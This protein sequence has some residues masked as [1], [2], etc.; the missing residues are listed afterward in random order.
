MENTSA[1]S[2]ILRRWWIVALCAVL[3]GALGGLPKPAAPE[4]D[5]STTY[6]ATHTMLVNDTQ[7]LQSSSNVVSPNQVSLLATTGEVPARV[8]E[9]IGSDLNSATLASQISVIFDPSTA[10]TFAIDVRRATSV[11]AHVVS[12]ISA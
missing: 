4:A 6:R 11:L 9:E 3:G 2:L 8:A 1:L 7:A 10:T 12:P 5:A